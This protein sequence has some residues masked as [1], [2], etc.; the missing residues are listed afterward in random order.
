MHNPLNAKVKL[1]SIALVKRLR[2]LWLMVSAPKV[3][4]KRPNRT[5]FML[6][7]SRGI[8][9]IRSEVQ[10][11]NRPMD[12]PKAMITEKKTTKPPIFKMDLT[13]R[14]IAWV[15]IWINGSDT[16]AC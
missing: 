12:S 11:S 10:K 6:T 1:M 15:N 13:P 7:G 4:S 9:G 2:L 16:G 3:I 14:V 5:P 8:R